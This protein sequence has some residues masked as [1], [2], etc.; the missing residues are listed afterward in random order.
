MSGEQTIFDQMLIQ[1]LITLRQWKAAQ[2]LVSAFTPDGIDHLP[3]LAVVTKRLKAT[4][5]GECEDSAAGE[6]LA[7]VGW[8]EPPLHSDIPADELRDLVLSIGH[9]LS[10]AAEY[11][12]VDDSDDPRVVL[13]RAVILK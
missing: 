10:I 13:R 2:L 8:D 6:L 3:D 12:G 9:A 4:V 7:L 5:L 1:E 11:L